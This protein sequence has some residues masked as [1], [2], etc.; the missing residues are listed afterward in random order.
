MLTITGWS[1]SSDMV[2]QWYA[3]DSIIEAGGRNTPKRLSEENRAS[4][5][6]AG[7]DDL[8][9]EIGWRCRGQICPTH[10]TTR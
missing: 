6:C 10:E 7:G 8:T 1:P 2:L 3:A 4:D 9:D 5:G